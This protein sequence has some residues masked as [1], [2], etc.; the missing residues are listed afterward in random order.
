M[1]AARQ[2]RVSRFARASRSAP[3][4]VEA[5][6]ERVLLAANTLIA[7]N[8]A[9]PTATA[10]VVSSVP[11]P[12]SGTVT[13]TDGGTTTYGT[14]ALKNLT[15]QPVFTYSATITLR[16]PPGT[17]TVVATYN[18]DSLHNTS[19]ST[20]HAVVLPSASLALGAA[21]G[22]GGIVRVIDV[23][24]GAL[25]T[26]L[27]YAGFNG[28]VRLAVGDVNADGFPDLITVPGQGGAPFVKV[29]DVATGD[30]LR[31]FLAFDIAFRGGVNLAVGDVNGDGHADIVTAPGAGGGPVVKEFSGA[32]GSQLTAFFAFPSTFTGGVQ[33]ATGDVNGDGN[34]DVGVATGP[35]AAS[36]VRVYGGGTS[37]LLFSQVIG[38]TNYTGGTVISM[39]DYDLDGKAEIATAFGPHSASIIQGYKVGTTGRYFAF[40]PYE[41]SFV[42][43]T[44]FYLTSLDVNGDGVD[45]LV[46]NTQ[47]TNRLRFISG[48][49]G[50]HFTSLE[51]ALAG[52]NALAAFNLGA[53]N[54]PA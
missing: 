42:N 12:L 10:Y 29:F 47:G 1:E 28:T 6:E 44:G 27:P 45:D 21:P 33:V 43:T 7:V 53:F 18:G 22:Q 37:T 48:R 39:G 4:L 51:A 50:S 17:R 19:T 20:L 30:L 23:K 5:C 49:D 40:N 16:L 24:T 15:R 34:A 13:F 32:D 26:L 11:G 35:G 36:Q 3:L 54:Q 38:P 9:N 14:V 31:S 2:V 25:R 46:V 8:Y 52:F 41:A